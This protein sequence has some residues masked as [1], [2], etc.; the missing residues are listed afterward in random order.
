MTK[1]Q[2]EVVLAYAENDMNAKAA[3]RKLY[4]HEANV[5]YHLKRIQKQ[6]GWNPKKFYDLCYLVGIAAQRLGGKNH[7]NK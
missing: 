3:A 5:S 7:E 1:Q 6:M 4:M 2:A